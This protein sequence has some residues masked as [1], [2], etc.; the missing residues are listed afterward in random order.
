MPG[1][2][3]VASDIQAVNNPTDAIHGV[4]WGG[5]NTSLVALN[6]SNVFDGVVL[7][8]GGPPPPSCHATTASVYISFFCG[9]GL[10]RVPACSCVSLLVSAWLVWPCVV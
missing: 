2:L 10:V 4:P 8:Y 5:V 9:F 1:V 7:T 6:A 3:H